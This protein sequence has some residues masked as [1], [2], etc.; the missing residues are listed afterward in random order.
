VEASVISVALAPG[1]TLDEGGQTPK[2]QIYLPLVL[3]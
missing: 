2:H 1:Y 3:R